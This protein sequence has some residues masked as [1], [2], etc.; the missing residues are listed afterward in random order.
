MV[1]VIQ[2]VLELYGQNSGIHLLKSTIE[3]SELVAAW[4]RIIIVFHFILFGNVIKMCMM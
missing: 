4:Y 2:S 1:I 3:H